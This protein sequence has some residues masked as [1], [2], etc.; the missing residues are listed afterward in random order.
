MTD[1]PQHRARAFAE[2]TGV[3]IRTLHFYDRIGLLR[4]HRTRAG[5]RLYSAADAETLRLIRVMKFIGVPLKKIKTLMR[6]GP[7][8]L[9]EA[10]RD[11]RR[12]LETRRTA[13]DQAIGA[14]ADIEQTLGAHRSID[15]A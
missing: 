6:S 15:G 7:D 4:P 1:T 5:H 8:R 9:A 11:Q 13:L 10:V 12:L 14:L 2:I 3:T